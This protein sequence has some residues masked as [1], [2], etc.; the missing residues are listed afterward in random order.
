MKRSSLSGS[1]CIIIL[2][3]HCLHG[4]MAG[5]GNTMEVAEGGRTDLDHTASHGVDYG[6]KVSSVVGS[7]RNGG[8]QRLI[9][10]VM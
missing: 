10:K 4:K 5:N 3:L 7:L 2:A 9:R 1:M 8:T 6:F